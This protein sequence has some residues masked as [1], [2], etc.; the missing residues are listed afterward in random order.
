M[1]DVI[2]LVDQDNAEPAFG[3]ALALAYKVAR[4]PLAAANACRLAEARVVIL[5]SSLRRQS[6][7]ALLAEGT[8]DAGAHRAALPSGTLAPGTYVVLLQA[9]GD[10]FARPLTVVR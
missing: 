6:E 10:R 8:R 4:I 1:I 7:V 9:G 2:I 5:H 3:S